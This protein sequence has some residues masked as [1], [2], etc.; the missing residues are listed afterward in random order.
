MCSKIYD[1]ATDFEGWRFAKKTKIYI[2]WKRNIF[3]EIK[4][5]IYYTLGVK[6][7]G[8]NNFFANFFKN[9]KF[10][11]AGH[12]EGLEAWVLRAL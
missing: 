5:F 7:V 4:K 2:S 1:D 10:P 8:R 12:G 3:L 9:P 6:N 11:V